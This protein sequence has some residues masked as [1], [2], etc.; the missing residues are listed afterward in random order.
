MIG[1]MNQMINAEE[2]KFM[3]KVKTGGAIFAGSL[4][5]SKKSWKDL[6]Q[7]KIRDSMTSGI[8]SMKTGLGAMEY[9]IK[10]DE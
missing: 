10:K 7:G 3:D 1:S 6:S 9:M 8:G 2:N 5:Q 4:L